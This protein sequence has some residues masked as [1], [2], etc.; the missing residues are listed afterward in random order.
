MSVVD[1]GGAVL[2]VKLTFPNV[3]SLWKQNCFFLRSEKYLLAEKVFYGDLITKVQGQ[4]I[5]D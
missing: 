2:I 1:L 5:P 3:V 4:F